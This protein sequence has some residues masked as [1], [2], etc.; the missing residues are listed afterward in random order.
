MYLRKWRCVVLWLRASAD[1]VV[2]ADN[3]LGDAGAAAVAGICE[4]IFTEHSNLLLLDLGGE[5]ACA[6]VVG[7]RV[8]C[9]GALTQLY[10]CRQ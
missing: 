9:A 4:G 5:Y 10:G 7:A 2:R 8:V 6:A 1:V 3:R